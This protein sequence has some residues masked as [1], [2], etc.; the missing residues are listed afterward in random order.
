MKENLGCK[1]IAWQSSNTMDTDWNFYCINNKTLK[2]IIIIKSRCLKTGKYYLKHKPF[3]ISLYRNQLQAWNMI[4]LMLD[5]LPAIIILQL[6]Q[7]GHSGTLKRWEKILL[8]LP[9]HQVVNYIT[10]Q[11]WRK[12]IETFK[13]KKAWIYQK[14]VSIEM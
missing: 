12:L 6:C 10:I 2:S 7:Y 3:W 13:I 5:F 9:W 11:Q 1:C 4:T 14:N 8:K